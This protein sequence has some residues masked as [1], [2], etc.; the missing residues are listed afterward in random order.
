MKKN[1]TIV[2]MLYIL[3]QKYGRD[4]EK[5]ISSGTA[6]SGLQLVFLL[7]GQDITQFDGLKTMLHDGDTVAL[8]PPIAGGRQAS[9]PGSS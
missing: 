4:F 9:M 3:T 8:V 5:Y 1:S 6:Q 7:N 2:D